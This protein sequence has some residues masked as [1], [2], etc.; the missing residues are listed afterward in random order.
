MYYL[1]SNLIN[2]LTG[3]NYRLGPLIC[4]IPNVILNFHIPNNKIFHAV[5]V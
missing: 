1:N 2:T 3:T 4:V 5:G